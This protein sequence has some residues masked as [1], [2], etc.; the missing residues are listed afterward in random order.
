[1][2][3]TAHEDQFSPEPSLEDECRKARAK[4]KGVCILDLSDPIC[5]ICGTS[6]ATITFRYGYIFCPLCGKKYKVVK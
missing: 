4:A 3:D 1:M 2:S 5:I 6:L